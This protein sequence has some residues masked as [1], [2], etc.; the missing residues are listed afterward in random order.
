M[1]YLFFFIIIGPMKVLYLL[2][3]NKITLIDLSLW[4]TY[5]VDNTKH[6]ILR[7]KINKHF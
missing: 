6:C 1:T 7:C 2:K 3:F 5:F 4:Q